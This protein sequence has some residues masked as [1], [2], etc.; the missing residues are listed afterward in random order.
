MQR[1]LSRFLNAPVL[2]TNGSSRC[3]GSSIRTGRTLN[4]PYSP[5]RHGPGSSRVPASSRPSSPVYPERNSRVRS[6]LPSDHPPGNG[7]SIQSE[8]PCKTL[9]RT[10]YAIGIAMGRSTTASVHGA[11]QSSPK[12]TVF[13][14]ISQRKISSFSASAHRLCRDFTPS[15][16][17]GSSQQVHVLK[18][19]D[20]NPA[21]DAA[22]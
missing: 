4:P 11:C 7:S 3:H 2:P 6:E 21:I 8:Q 12:A 20:F 17:S 18:G 15:S 10:S 5:A 9:H 19:R 16:V 1:F 13:Q 22:T 14:K